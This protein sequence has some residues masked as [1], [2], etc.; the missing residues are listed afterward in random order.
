MKNTQSVIITIINSTPASIYFLRQQ[1]T[2]GRGWGLEKYHGFHDQEAKQDQLAIFSNKC[3]SNV[4]YYDVDDWQQTTLR[5]MS[6]YKWLEYNC[7]T[8]SRVNH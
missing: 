2:F 7:Y 5:G 1:V 6:Q 8:S 4:D 3:G